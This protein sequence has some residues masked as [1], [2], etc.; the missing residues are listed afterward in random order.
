MRRVLVGALFTMLMSW[1]CAGGN[2]SSTAAP[3]L[4]PAPAPTVTAVT[5]TGTAPTVGASAQFVA[6]A[7]LSNASAQTVTSQATWSSS[8]TAVATVNGSGLV[9]AVAAGEADIAASYQSV[10]GKLHVTIALA[11]RTSFSITGVV[12]DAFNGGLL[13]GATVAAAEQSTTTDGNGRFVIASVS[14]GSVTVTAARTGFVTGSRTLDLS[15]DTQM[16]FALDRVASPSPTPGPTPTPTPG[17]SSLPAISNEAKRYVID[18]N[19]NAYGGGQGVARWTN[20]PIRVWAE[21]GFRA[22]DLQEAVNIW[23]SA[24]GGRVT[25]AIV[26]SANQAN[27]VFD[28]SGQGIPSGSCGVEGPGPISNFLMSSGFGHYLNQ[29]QCAPNGEWRIGLAH[30]LGH[31][32]GL[33]G[34]TPSGSDLMGSPSSI[35]SMSPLLSE[36]MTWIYSV[37]PG[38]RLQ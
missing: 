28:L 11:A 23:Q 38:T 24:T 17:P 18:Y 14:A 7:T 6:N 8:A 1:A 10:S 20:F 33:G 31:I 22:Q 4:T 13:N 37:P 3:T 32:L 27:I 26:P 34:H 25:F 30:G 29:P 21:S 2:S 36:I 15:A 9:S 12:T 5:I 16:N 35:W 19:Q